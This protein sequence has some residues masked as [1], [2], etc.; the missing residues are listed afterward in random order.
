MAK[1]GKHARLFVSATLIAGAGA[2]AMTD[3]R[4]IQTA[5]GALAPAWLGLTAEPGDG[6]VVVRWNPAEPF[7]E[8]SKYAD[9]FIEDGTRRSVTRL[10]PDQIA[11]GSAEYA[12]FTDDV[13]F[14]LVTYGGSGRS[15]EESVRVV[16]NMWTGSAD[17]MVHGASDSF[18][19]PGSV[20]MRI[21]PREVNY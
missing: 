6:E 16:G 13:S 19:E 5:R 7:V 14:R 18:H 15:E 21:T 4:V 12:P 10:R 9:L 3:Y 8:T 11:T 2:L 17:R 20:I 1:L